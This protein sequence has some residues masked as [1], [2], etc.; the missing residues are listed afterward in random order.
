EA[1][2]RWMQRWPSVESRA[3]ASL[4]EVLAQWQ[5]LGYPRRARDLHRSARIVVGTGWPNDLQD[6]PGGGPYIAAAVRCFSGG[7]PVLPVD[8]NVKRVLTRRLPGGSETSAD[9]GGAGPA[10]RGVGERG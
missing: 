10:R 5:G 2:R 1:W 6:L 4:A 8:V 9:P 7:E 3:A